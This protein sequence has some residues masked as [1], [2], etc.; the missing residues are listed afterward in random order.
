MEKFA[1]SAVDSEILDASHLVTEMRED[2]EMLESFPV[3]L[4]ENVATFH[5]IDGGYHNNNGYHVVNLI[6][7]VQG[8]GSPPSDVRHDEVEAHLDGRYYYLEV[9]GVTEYQQY[10][11]EDYFLSLHVTGYE[12]GPYSFSDE[13]QKEVDKRETEYSYE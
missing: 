8:D 3:L 11:Q 9:S 13:L 2:S 4:G 6:H 12:R 7:T 1:V 5:D 10:P